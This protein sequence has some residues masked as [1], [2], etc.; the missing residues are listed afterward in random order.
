MPFCLSLLVG[1]TNPFVPA[2][3]GTPLLQSLYTVLS[4]NPSGDWNRTRIPFS[5]VLH[6]QHRGALLSVFES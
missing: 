3:A 5:F 2:V 1:T 6:A 4:R